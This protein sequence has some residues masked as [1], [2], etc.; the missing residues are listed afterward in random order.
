MISGDVVLQGSSRSAGGR[1]FHRV[2]SLPRAAAR[3]RRPL[4]DNVPR[5]HP[6]LRVHRSALRL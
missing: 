2:H 5:N 4:Q 6:R 1:R 3:A